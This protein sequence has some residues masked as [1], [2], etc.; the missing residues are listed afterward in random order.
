MI[1]RKLELLGILVLVLVTFSLP[2]MASAET[3]AYAIDPVH[4]SADWQIRHLF[5]KVSG[6]FSDVTGK[7]WIDRNNLAAS[8]V[9]ATISVSSLDTNHQKRDSHLRSSDFF[10]LEKYATIRFASKS[11][12][13]TGKDEGIMHGDLTIRGVTHSVKMPFKVLGFG[14]DP[15]GG[16]RSGFQARYELNRSDYGITYGLDKQGG[17]SVGNEV[18]VNLLIEAIKLGPDGAPYKV[19]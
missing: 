5:S 7:I 15:W 11:V 17:G 2:L 9:D 8:R 3:E 10:D 16:Y 13:P 19:K 12:E 6:T 18:E 14:P 4:S 1:K